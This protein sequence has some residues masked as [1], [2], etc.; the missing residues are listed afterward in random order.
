[1][2]YKKNKESSSDGD[3]NDNV[4]SGSSEL[5]VLSGVGLVTAVEDAECMFCSEMFHKTS[6]ENFGSCVSCIA[7]GFMYNVWG[8]KKT[9]TYVTVVALDF[10]FQMCQFFIILLR[11]TIFLVS[12]NLCSTNLPFL[13]VI[14]THFKIFL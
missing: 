4:S 11:F 9:L 7:S 10:I 5:E 6:K 2:P 8:W 1:M 13:F 14:F 3:L 12:I